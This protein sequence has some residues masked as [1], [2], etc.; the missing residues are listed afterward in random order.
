MQISVI[1]FYKIKK[2]NKPE[3]YRESLKKYFLSN[4]VK[5]TVII[6]PEGINGTISG[7]KNNITNCLNYL[8]KN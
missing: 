3:K 8:K 4:S 5:G 2:I 1:G 7:K 6:A